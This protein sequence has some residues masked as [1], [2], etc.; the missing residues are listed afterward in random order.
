MRKMFELVGGF[1]EKV[2]TRLKEKCKEKKGFYEL[3][4]YL[5]KNYG[6]QVYFRYPH[7]TIT[8]GGGLLSVGLNYETEVRKW[9]KD[10]D[11][12]KVIYEATPL[13]VI[14]NGDLLGDEKVEICCD[15]FL[16]IFISLAQR[17]PEIAFLNKTRIVA[18]AV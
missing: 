8:K 5:I 2:E 3:D 9:N 12:Y 13:Y 7:M 6:L 15:Y 17:A 18:K 10:Q 11:S 4:N 14:S 16:E 1:V